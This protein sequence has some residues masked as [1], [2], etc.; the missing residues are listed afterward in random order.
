MSAAKDRY[1]NRTEHWIN[2]EKAASDYIDELEEQNLKLI[3][4]L[5]ELLDS[6]DIKNKETGWNF[7]WAEVEY[8]NKV[9]QSVTGGKQ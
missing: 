5:K 3:E 9:I 8:A 4:A 7:A 6:V 1:Y 2:P